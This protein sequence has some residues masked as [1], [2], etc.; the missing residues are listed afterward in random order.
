MF[1]QENAHGKYMSKVA[2]QRRSIQ[3]SHK[4]VIIAAETMWVFS[5]HISK[6]EW[7]QKDL[8]HDQNSNKS[9]FT[10]KFEHL[11]K[12]DTLELGLDYWYVYISMYMLVIY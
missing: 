12:F 3:L 9:L 11:K 5:G 1:P 10:M 8:K 2:G 7:I 6:L 4:G